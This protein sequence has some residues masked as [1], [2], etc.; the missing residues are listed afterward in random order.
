MDKVKEKRLYDI[1]GGTKARLCIIFCALVHGSLVVFSYLHDIK[2]LMY[3][4][5]LSVTIYA[6]CNLIADKRPVWVYLI[7][8]FEIIIHSFVCVLLIGHGFGFSAYFICLVPIGFNFLHAA[9]EK[10]YMMKACVMSAISFLLYITCYYYSIHHE[11]IYQSEALKRNEPYIYMIN[12]FITFTVLIV[13]SIMFLIEIEVAFDALYAKNRRLGNLANTDPLTGLFNRR[14]MTE[15][16]KEMYQDY[17][18]Y[19]KPFC[20]IIC[21][22]DDFKKIN[23]TYGHDCGD[24]VLIS[25]SKKLS[26]IVRGHD[27]LCRWGGEE[28]L[29]LLKNIEIDNARIIAERIREHIEAMKI[30]Y[31]DIHVHITMTFGVASAAESEDYEGLFKIADERLYEG[32]KS[33]K[34]IVK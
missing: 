15:H 18:D 30:T 1:S 31:K 26:D 14:T 3:F 29:I 2:P 16:V 32:K 8:Y 23:D 6:L 11:P 21:D 34:N 17:V 24:E 4:N 9:K 20:L 10:H 25:I 7:S 12:I 19:K 22:I 27:F 13:F 5:M 28:F 33:G